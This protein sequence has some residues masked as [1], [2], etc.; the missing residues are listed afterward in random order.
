VHHAAFP[1]RRTTTRRHECAARSAASPRR[2]RRTRQDK[3][4]SSPLPQ[5]HEFVAS[6]TSI[7]TSSMYGTAVPQHTFH[8]P[9]MPACGI[10]I[11][12][13]PARQPRV[14]CRD[15]AEGMQ[16][17]E[18]FETVTGAEAQQ[19]S[20]QTADG[21]RRY[22]QNPDTGMVD[23]AFGMDRSLTQTISRTKP[24]QF[25]MRSVA[26]HQAHV[27]TAW[28]SRFPRSTAIERVRFIENG[29][30]FQ[31]PSLSSPS[32]AT[33]VPAMN[34]SISSV[35]RSSRSG[36]SASMLTMRQSP[37]Q[38]VGGHRRESRRGSRTMLPV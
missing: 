8:T 27:A 26:G 32:T 19:A 20:A 14:V 2:C 36:T 10:G 12:N 29:E 17:H 23:A 38:A 11:I 37:A 33:S 7:T 31:V 5:R 22:L 16:Q 6:R 28:C 35:S 25:S 34:S 13:T 1:Q 3:P 9:Q 18:L 30:N 4:N 24:R 21:A 15:A